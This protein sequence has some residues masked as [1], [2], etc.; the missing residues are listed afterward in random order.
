MKKHQI[1]E[2]YLFDCEKPIG[3]AEENYECFL[4]KW[5]VNGILEVRGIK[6]N[7]EDIK[8]YLNFE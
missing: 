3:T 4:K 5:G 1:I 7:L 8:Y 2:E 6:I